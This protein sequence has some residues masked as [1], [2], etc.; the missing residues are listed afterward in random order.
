MLKVGRLIVD[1][2]EDSINDRA[3]S[4]RPYVILLVQ[5]CGYLRHFLHSLTGPVKDH[6]NP[7]SLKQLD[8][9]QQKVIVGISEDLYE[10]LACQGLHL[11][12]NGHPTLEL[13][14]QLSRLHLLEG[15]CTHK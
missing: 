11:G 5:L 2:F 10:V 4:P 3:Q 12:L 6:I 7:L 8:S 14:R 13:N 15:T 9:L 1:V